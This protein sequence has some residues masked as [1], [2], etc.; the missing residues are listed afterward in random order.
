MPT[1]TRSLPNEFSDLQLFV[2]DWALTTEKERFDRLHSITLDQ[3]KPFYDTMLARMDSI[4]EYLNQFRMGD[5]PSDA[6]TLFDLSMTFAETAHPLDL[7]WT[8]VDFNDAYP[9]HKFEFRT[10]S[11]ADQQ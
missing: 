1:E 3:L 11:C 9:W 4:L 7:K 6:R 5:M 8:D 2:N 10:V